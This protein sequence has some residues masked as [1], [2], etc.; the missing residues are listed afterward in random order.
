MENKLNILWHSNATWMPTGYGSQSRIW[1]HRLAK[2]GYG[3]VVSAYRGLEGRLISDGT[4]YHLPRVREQHANDVIYGHFL[5]AQSLYPDRQKTN[6]VWSLIDIFAMAA[7]LWKPL[8]WAAWTPVD[9]EPPL[10]NERA[11]FAA[12]RWPIA[13]SRHGEEQM[14]SIGLRPLYVPHG[15]ETDVFHPIDRS[16]ARLNLLTKGLINRPIPDDVFLVIIVGNNGEGGRKNF[17]GMFEAFQIF[18][19]KR[20]DARLYVHADP[21]GVHGLPLDA[22]VAQLGL[23]EKVIF[24]GETLLVEDDT[25][26]SLRSMGS[27][28][29][30]TGLPTDDNV[31]D[32]YNAADVK[33]ML[34]YGE[35]FGLTDVEAEACGTPLV[36]IG[37]SASIEVNFTGWKVK[38]TRFSPSNI[39]R[40]WQMLADLDHAAACLDNAYKLWKSGGMPALRERTHK[41]AQIYD[42]ETV[43]KDYFLPT[44]DQI[45]EELKAE[46]HDVWLKR[47]E[48]VPAPSPIWTKEKVLSKA[49]GK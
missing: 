40:S 22:M 41:A 7:H 42:V 26:G 29:M 48:N 45:A 34:S 15:I 32:V 44:L 1:T 23:S 43:L 12:C 6:L 39:P 20:P 14:K 13:M 27:Y 33:L 8:P 36:G 46:P 35:G 16:Q 5:Y 47:Q 3:V 25:M 49:K 38:G 19:Q 28:L 17:S 18:S 11:Q 2:E 30:T 31:R 10:Q 24:P 4:V 9:C 37:Y 21:A